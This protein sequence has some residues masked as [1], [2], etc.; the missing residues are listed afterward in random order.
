L[1][2]DRAAHRID[3]AGELDDQAVAHGARNTAAMCE[4]LGIDQV[5]PDRL[6]RRQSALFVDPHEAGVADN[7]GT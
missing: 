5:A 4:D 3:H 7:I 6:E 1:Y 2:F